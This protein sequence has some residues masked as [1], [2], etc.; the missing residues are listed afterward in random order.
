[1]RLTQDSWESNGNRDFHCYAGFVVKN[2]GIFPP[3]AP[4]WNRC[5]QDQWVSDS[6]WAGSWICG[7][8]DCS[9]ILNSL[10]YNL[11]GN[12]SE[13]G[14]PRQAQ[15][16]A[17]AFD[18]PLCPSELRHSLPAFP[19][20]APLFETTVTCIL[21]Y[22][23]SFT[24]TSKFWKVIHGN[25]KWIITLHFLPGICSLWNSQSARSQQSPRSEDK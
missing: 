18:W 9:P 16:D 3:A 15:E 23:G 14:V 1:M 11:E 8:G 10:L 19:S 5:S 17:L 4:Q 20:L 7:V 6:A 25:W 24:F 21:M 12:F 22:P 2:G 13:T